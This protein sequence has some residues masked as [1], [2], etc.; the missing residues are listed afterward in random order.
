MN[1]STA[2]IGLH[3]QLACIWEA[4]A[5]KPGNVH[6]FH[7]FADTGYIDFLTSAAAIAPVL[8]DAAGGF[9]GATVLEA[10]QR[11][12]EVARANTNLGII[13]L[14]APLAR[15]EAW[16]DGRA[17]VLSVL[18]GL[19]VEDAALVYQAIVLAGAGG[20]GQV[21]EQDVHDVPTVTLREAMALAADRDGIARQYV[22][23]FA[24]VFDHGA[25]ALMAGIERTGCLEGG[26][27]HA[28][29]HLMSLLPDTLIARK[30]GAA[31]AEESARRAAAVLE[32]GWPR[33][34]AGRAALVELDAWLRAEG[35]QRN[36]GTTADLTAASMFALLRQ[37]R[38]RLP[39]E[40]PWTRGDSWSVQ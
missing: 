27:I 1:P 21:P 37:R 10:V 3:A 8:A 6:P 25:P 33:T 9:V 14:L 18:E 20:L 23:G 16:P 11:T 38:L 4:T 39:L 22:N 7:D 28:H 35:H 26:I 30:R 5:R 15:V 36:P 29:L 32:S 17:G 19:S 13:L 31:E 34:A 12:R 40:V 24:D 2:T